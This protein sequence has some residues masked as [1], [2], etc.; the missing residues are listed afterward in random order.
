MQLSILV[1]LTITLIA[2]VLAIPLSF[3]TQPSL[4][5]NGY[6]DG[7]VS[8]ATISPTLYTRVVAIALVFA[9]ALPGLFF[10]DHAHLAG[11]GDRGCARRFVY[12]HWSCVAPQDG[13]LVSS[14]CD[15]DGFGPHPHV[16]P[17]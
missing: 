13:L 7:S 15:I 6:G 1:M 4:E 8:K 14:D 2:L 12:A 3:T 17:I 11:G 10:I 9:A 16:P 5:Y